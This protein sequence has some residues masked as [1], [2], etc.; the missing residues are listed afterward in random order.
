MNKTL[1]IAKIKRQQAELQEII[2]SL[3]AEKKGGPIIEI[4]KK[5]EEELVALIDAIQ[6]KSFI[7]HGDVSYQPEPVVNEIAEKVKKVKE[8]VKRLKE[9]KQ[10]KSKILESLRQ[11]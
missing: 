5:R 8:G 9:L 2:E 6:D 1:I 4:L 7:A 10:E 3:H 11:D